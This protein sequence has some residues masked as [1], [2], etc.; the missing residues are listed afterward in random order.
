MQLL[1]P[2]LWITLDTYNKTPQIHTTFLNTTIMNNL[3]TVFG[4]LQD[5]KI[6]HGDLHFN[7]IM[8]NTEDG[9]VKIIDWS[10]MERNE[11]RFDDR[12]NERYVF[13][14]QTQWKE[15]S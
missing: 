15:R 11:P 4:E 9:S 2:P 5:R 7:N 3:R 12:L 14:L 6:R 13:K 10:R 1:G 8:V